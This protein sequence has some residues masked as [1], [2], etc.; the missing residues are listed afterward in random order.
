MK[1][2]TSLAD[3]DVSHPSVVS[4]GNFDG[5]HLGHREILGTVVRRSRE[6]GLRA[7]AMT[8]SPHPMRF[9]VPDRPLRLIST[10]DQKIRLIED[11][12][13][14]MLFVAQFDTAFS[15]LSPEEFIEKYLIHGFTARS[16]CVGGNFNFGYRGSGTVETLRKFRQHFDI[17]EVGPVRVR[18]TLV[19]SSAIRQLVTDGAVSRA[20]RLLGRWVEIEGKLVSGA[21]RGRTIQVPT[22]NLESENELIP[23]MGVYVTRIS[24][25]DGPFMDAVTNI[26]VRPTFDGSELTIETFV[27]NEVVAGARRARLA[28]LYRLR[29]EIKFASS[30]ALRQQ[31]AVDV[32][33]A[34]K[35]FRAIKQQVDLNA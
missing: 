18:G 24:L 3:V 6:M 19:S 29:D 10:L 8:F 2:A 12:G 28:F 23:K 26:G 14:D 22:L 9:L 30:E 17:I 32:Q 20:C 1:I 13:I 16:V 31:I 11:S 15:R 4:I 27:L 25:D 7:V 5:L 21:G 33:R 34:Q 35:F